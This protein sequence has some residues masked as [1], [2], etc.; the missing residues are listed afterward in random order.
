MTILDKRWLQ[1]RYVT[2]P[3]VP[4]SL[5]SPPP[6]PTQVVIKEEMEIKEEAEDGEIEVNE[7]KLNL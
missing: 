7:V 1:E 3:D 2:K 5:I 6:L 4:T